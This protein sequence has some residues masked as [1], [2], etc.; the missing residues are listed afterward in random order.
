MRRDDD[1]PKFLGMRVNQ[2]RCDIIN[3]ERILM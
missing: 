2:L 1:M 3:F